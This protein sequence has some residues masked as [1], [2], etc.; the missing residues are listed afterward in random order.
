VPHLYLS[1]SMMNYNLDL[2]SPNTILAIS[3]TT[4]N[5]AYLNLCSPN[6]IHQPTTVGNRVL[7]SQIKNNR[8]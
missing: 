6:T 5:I 4:S 3:A 2:R 7:T 8:I 1:L